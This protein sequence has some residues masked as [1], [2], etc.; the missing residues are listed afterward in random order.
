LYAATASG[1]LAM[2]DL[3]LRAE[4]PILQTSPLRDYFDQLMK[5]QI[6]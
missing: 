1:G 3:P 6:A 2:K 5:G 4:K